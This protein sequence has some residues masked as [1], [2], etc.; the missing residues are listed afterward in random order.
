ME[1]AAHLAGWSKDPSTKV[2]AVIVGP[3]NDVRA[4][5][6]NG[7]PRGIDALPDRF[8]RPQ[9]Y[10]WIEHAERNAIYTAARNGVPLNGCRLYLNWF[11][12]AD[13]A[14]AI[15]QAGI[16]EVVSVEPDWNHE[17]WGEQFVQAKELL[18]VGTVDLRFLPLKSA[19]PE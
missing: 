15:L 3:D 4:I 14:R 8:M 16:V 11:P 2:G 19:S 18:S 1:L 6:Y 5:G 12:C 13:C 7:L 9:K 17:T 10:V